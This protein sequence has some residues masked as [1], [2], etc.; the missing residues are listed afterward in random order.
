M[1]YPFS[2]L[3]HQTM[4]TLA[5]LGELSPSAIA[6]TVLNLPPFRSITQDDFRLF[7]RHL[8]EIDHL[9]RTPEGGLIVGISAERLINNFKF[10]AIFPDTQEYIVKHNGKAIGSI[11]VPPMEGDR[12]SL[13]GKTWEVIEVNAKKKTIA[14]ELSKKSVT[15]SSWRGNTGEIH[16]K[17]LRRMKKV[18]QEETLYSYLQPGARQRLQDARELAQTTGFL[19]NP[20]QW[21]DEGVCCILPWIGTIA[22]RTLERFLRFYAKDA[23]GFKSMKARSPYFLTVRLGKCKLES[24]YAEIQSLRDRT[25][26]VSDLIK[27]DEALNFNKYDAYIPLELLE[28]AFIQDYLDLPELQSLL[29]DW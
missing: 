18:L 20:V 12:F 27:P 11:I 3:Y 25:I 2:L 14:V 23:L 1:R 21:V 17:V 6:Q 29:K 4:S 24:L 16:T 10:Y 9:E 26:T 8:L 13:A 15:S 22:F 28:K 7:L 19:R 5:S